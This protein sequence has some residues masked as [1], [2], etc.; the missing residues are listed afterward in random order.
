MLRRRRLAHAHGATKRHKT[1]R[2]AWGQAYF[3]IVKNIAMNAAG[4]G[5]DPPSQKPKKETEPQPQFFLTLKTKNVMINY[6]VVPRKNPQTK[7]VKYYAQSMRT[8]AMNLNQIAANISREST[9]H[10]ADVKAV[11]VCLEEQIVLALQNG[12]SVVFGD[13]GSFH[14]S[15]RSN[16]ADAIKE[17]DSDRINK[18]L[19]RF[20]ASS[21][22]RKSLSVKNGQVSFNNVTKAVA[23]EA[24]TTNA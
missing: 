20:R 13:L 2:A 4:K 9:V 12:N 21:T 17:F 16:G 14:A 8:T 19:V 1:T 10:M 23:A 6:K 22:M 15:L 3:C 11:L 5:S 24:S 18:V 7:A